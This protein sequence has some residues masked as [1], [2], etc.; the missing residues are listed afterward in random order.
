M[1]TFAGL[2]I[3]G[4]FHLVCFRVQQKY[5]S[6][7]LTSTL[8]LRGRGQ[9]QSTLNGRGNASFR[10]RKNL[11]WNCN[12]GFQFICPMYGPRCSRKSWHHQHNVSKRLVLFAM[13]M[14]CRYGPLAWKQP[15]SHLGVHF[16]FALAT[17]LRRVWRVAVDTLE[18]ML[19]S[20]SRLGACSTVLNT[21]CLVYRGRKNLAFCFLSC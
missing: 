13:P 9:E 5:P 4:A 3:R 21:A 8:N 7:V 11:M 18:S 19:P 17:L 2:G 1:D 6:H 20:R 12:K 14:P 10:Y 15:P 16:L